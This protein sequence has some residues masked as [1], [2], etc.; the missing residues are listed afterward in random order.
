MRIAQVAEGVYRIRLGWG[1]A[2]LL[3]EGERSALIDTGLQQDRAD[4]VAALKE[5]GVLPGMLEAVYLTHAHCDHAGNAA[6][7]AGQ[8]ARLIAHRAEAPYMGLPRRAYVPH[9]WKRLSRPHTMLMFAAAERLY[10]V[11]RRDADGL[12]EEGEILDAPGGALR[13]VH[14]PGHTPGHSA[15]WRERDRVLFSGDAIMNIIPFRRIT[16][17]SLPIRAFSDDWQQCK[18]SARRLAELRP[19]TLL[20]GHGRPLTEEAAA[21]LEAWTRTLR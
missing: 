5:I 20:A 7:L 10:P 13:V 6:W 11:E 19:A 17:L 12:V 14:S 1:N 18:Q 15:F 16:A 9:K 3:H 8:G 21:Q 2:Y 4:L